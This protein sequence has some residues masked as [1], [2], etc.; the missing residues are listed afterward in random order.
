MTSGSGFTMRTP[1]LLKTGSLPGAIAY[2]GTRSCHAPERGAELHTREMGSQATVEPG[3]ERD[4]TVGRAVE[5][6]LQRVGERLGI[7][8]RGRPQHR[9]HVAFL[10]VF[11]V[12]REVGGRE[13]A[14]ERHRRERAEQLF[15]RGGEHGGVVDQLLTL[16]GMTG[17][18]RHHVRQRRRHRVEPGDQQQEH[19]VED[20]LATQTVAVDLDRQEAADQVVAGLVG[21]EAAIE[22]GVQEVVHAPDDPV[23]IRLLLGGRCPLRA[24]RRVLEFEEVVDHVGG[25]AHELEE[26]ARRQRHAER[27]VELDLGLVDEPVDQLVGHVDDVRLEV[28]DDPWRE[29]RIEELAELRV[30]GT[31]DLQRD[32]WTLV[33]EDALVVVPGGHPRAAHDVAALRGREE[34]GHLR[35]GDDTVL[36]ERARLLDLEEDRAR[37]LDR[38]R[39][40]V[41]GSDPAGVTA[42]GG[43][44]HVL[45]LRGIGHRSAPRCEY[46]TL[47]LERARFCPRSVH[48]A[49]FPASGRSIAPPPWRSAPP[50]ACR[51]SA[52]RRRRASRP[53]RPGAR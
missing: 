23:L 10:H 41:E 20:L 17:E 44:V 13:A 49:S 27:L 31:V 38:E 34:V 51:T 28:R 6:D 53:A 39:L 47:G 24:D 42:L 4:V 45:L 50:R 16:L 30:L 11:T 26:D 12:H 52:A 18:V 3:R 48:H 29:Q 33:P 9:D 25:Q 40:E 43:L 21:G 14:A 7:D 2:S 22:L 46:L 15:D 37:F 32:E 5:V 35:D 8:V 1:S 36:T 19:D